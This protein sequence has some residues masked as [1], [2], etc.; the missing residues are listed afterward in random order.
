ME[1]F[2]VLMGVTSLSVLLAAYAETNEA[3]AKL[4]K[5]SAANQLAPISKKNK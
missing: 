4:I 3:K 5:E 1:T 2:Q